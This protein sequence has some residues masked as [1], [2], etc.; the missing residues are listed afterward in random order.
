MRGT[1][2]LSAPVDYQLTPL[3]DGGWC[4][5]AKVC[6]H[7][8]CIETCITVPGEVAKRVHDRVM[9]REMAK[10]PTFGWNPF[11]AAK[12]A[13][14]KVKAVVTKQALAPALKLVEKSAVIPQAARLA[15]QVSRATGLPVGP[16]QMVKAFRLAT[17]AT[18]GNAKA[19]RLLGQAAQ[20]AALGNPTA[21]ASMMALK[22]IG[23]MVPQLRPIADA[24][25]SPA[26][27]GGAGAQLARAALPAI[28]GVC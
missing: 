10:A 23:P 11:K 26:W 3:P 14:R 27:P 17:N 9:R 20:L 12:K 24:V 2:A 15:A 28:A 7:G 19:R 21:M 13:V 5:K 18:M 16:D 1:Y 25:P 6:I 4:G 8:V 22:A